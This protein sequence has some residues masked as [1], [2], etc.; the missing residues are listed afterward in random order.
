MKKSAKTTLRQK[1]IEDLAKDAHAIRDGQLKARLA[2]R[3]EGKPLAM[4]YRAGRRQLA[5]IQT[6]ISEKAAAK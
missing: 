4:N 3:T 1:S 5:R 6:I 2:T